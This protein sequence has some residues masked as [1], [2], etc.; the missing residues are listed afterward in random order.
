VKLDEAE[1]LIDRLPAC[2]ATRA[3]RWT[4]WS[5][6]ARRWMLVVVPVALVLE[7]LA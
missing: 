7:R 5:W 2:S 3:A 4:L 1:R 6:I